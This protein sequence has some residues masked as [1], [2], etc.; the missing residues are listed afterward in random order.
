[1]TALTALRLDLALAI[2]AFL[3]FLIFNPMISPGIRC[4]SRRS[5]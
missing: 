4:T 1:M 3:V 5:G 2:V